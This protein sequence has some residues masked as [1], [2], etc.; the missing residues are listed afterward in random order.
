[1]ALSKP[2][3]VRKGS[4]IM[5]SRSREANSSTSSTSGWSSTDSASHSSAGREDNSTSRRD[6]S[7]PNSM[8]GKP[9]PSAVSSSSSLGK[10]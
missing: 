10:G 8:T 4:A 3:A 7:D 5:R 1:M 2:V 9:W 6:P